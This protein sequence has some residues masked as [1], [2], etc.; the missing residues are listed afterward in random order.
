MKAFAHSE[1]ERYKTEAQERWGNT[2]AYKEYAGKTR[3][4]GKDKWN[5][6]A[7]DLD[8]IFGEFAI[9]MKNGDAPDA[10]V[11]QTLVKKLQN[12]ISENYYNCTGEI[13]SGLGQMYVADERFRKNIDQHA[14]GT[15]AFVSE[16]ISCYNQQ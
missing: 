16:A 8:S 11:P 5:R 4:Y 7:A 10:E 3:N 14:D 1:F 15:A 12:H 2:D 13:L 9:C 6:L